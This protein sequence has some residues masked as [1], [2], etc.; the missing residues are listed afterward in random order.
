MAGFLDKFIIEQF[1]NFK[2]SCMHIKSFLRGIA[3]GFLL[4]VLYAPDRGEVTR[5]KISKKTSDVKDA[6]KNTYESIS[7]TV[8]KVKN[9]ANQMLHKDNETGST[10]TMGISGSNSGII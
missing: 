6:V 3:V 5:R 8:S 1:S 4:G 7:G 10:P 9:K 2:N